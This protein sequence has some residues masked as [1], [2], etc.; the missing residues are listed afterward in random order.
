MNLELILFLILTLVAAFSSVMVITRKNPILSAV[1]LIL[2]FFALAGIYLLL[3]A[4]FLSV[5]QVIV[6]AGAIM[7]LFLFVIMLI[8]TENESSILADKKPIKVFAIFIAVLVFS[9]IA[10]LIFYSNPSGL[11]QGTIVNSITAG[12]IESIGRELYTTY[13]L[14]FLIAGYLLLV[15][16]MGAII[17]AKKK[18]E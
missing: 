15:A 16:T 1:Y 11:S 10:Y 2:N 3:N 5:V 14:P 17:L 18:F 12:Q 4:Q 9:Q 6:Y 7:I 8:N 13:I